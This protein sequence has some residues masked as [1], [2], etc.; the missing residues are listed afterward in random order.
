MVE[1]NS[2]KKNHVPND[3]LREARE[4]RGWAHKDVAEFIDL[5]DAHTVGRW[6]RGVSFPRPYYRQRLCQLFGKSAEELGLLKGKS[7][8]NQQPPLL[9][10]NE[11]LSPYIWKIPPS[12]TSFVGREQEIV[13]VR[14]LLEHGDTRLVTLLGPGVLVRRV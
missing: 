11:Q 13:A 6:E 1:N 14:A 12:F 7:G 9:S 3:R 2:S 8:V 10:E 5:P 4:Q